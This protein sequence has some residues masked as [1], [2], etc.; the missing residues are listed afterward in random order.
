MSCLRYYSSCPLCCHYI[1]PFR[2]QYATCKHKTIVGITH[3]PV[4]EEKVI[5][6]EE[7]HCPS[8]LPTVMP[9]DLPE[10][11]SVIFCALQKEPIEPIEPIGSIDQIEPVLVLSEP[12]PIKTLIDVGKRGPPSR[13]IVSIKIVGREKKIIIRDNATGIISVIRRPV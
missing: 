4:Y 5:I 7:Q 6:F 12:A 9:V 2:R 13:E 1:R 3:D 11:V 10:N 8:V